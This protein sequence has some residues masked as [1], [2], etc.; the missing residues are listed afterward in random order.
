MCVCAL[1]EGGRNALYNFLCSFSLR[2][3]CYIQVCV[4]VCVLVEG[5]RDDFYNFL[6]S[7]SLRVRCYI[8]ACVCMC[9]SG[10]R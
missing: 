9:A 8:Q 1:V 5:G 10:R 4:Y 7:F 6:C 2:V 3:R